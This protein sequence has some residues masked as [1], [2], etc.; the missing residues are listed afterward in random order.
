VFVTLSPILTAPR[1]LNGRQGL[2]GCGGREVHS[3]VSF[4]V[5]R[6]FMLIHLP[7]YCQC[8]TGGLLWV[9][10]L[11]F[12]R[13]Q[14]APSSTEHDF[15]RGAGMDSAMAD[16]SN[17]SLKSRPLAVLIVTLYACD[18]VKLSQG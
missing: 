6:V 18:P 12:G 4:T 8:S 2:V 7:A 15:G 10:S 3:A 5:V 17:A 16:E 14:H 1:G 9:T 11:P 13:F